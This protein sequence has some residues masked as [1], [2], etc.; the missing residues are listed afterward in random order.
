MKKVIIAAVAENMVIGQDGDIPWHFPEDLKHFKQVT[1]GSPVV[2][3]RG[4]YESL[5]ED[6]KP[7]PGRTNIVLTRSNPDYE[8]SVKLANSLDE[9]W[10]IASEKGEKVY[11]I[12][13]AS[14]YEQT[15]D[16]ADKMILTEI[17]EEY[18]GDTYFPKFSKEE[19]KEVERN[20]REELSFV[21]YQNRS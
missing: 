15:L 5:P 17:H 11:I 12:G 16:S 6:F 3:G 10:Q 2:M 19:W 20:D 8:E 4:T 13:G 1:M 9:A 21:T 18:E 7:L 14:V